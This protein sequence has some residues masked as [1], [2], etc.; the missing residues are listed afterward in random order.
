MRA[1][2]AAA[3]TP[4]TALSDL[5]RP[6]LAALRAE[7]DACRAW[8]FGEALPFWATRGVDPAG[9]F[10]ER[11]TPDGRPTREPRRARLI[12]R[13]VYAFATARGLGWDGPAEAL[14]RMGLATLAQR[15][16]CP[17]GMV[18][19]TYGPDAGRVNARFDLYD[20]AFVLFAKAA[21]A[22]GGVAPADGLAEEARGLLER[23]RAGWAHPEAGFEESVPRALP[24]RANPHM[25]LL[26][27]ALAWSET[28][29]DPCWTAAAEEIV[30]LCLSRF[31]DPATGALR[32]VFDGDWRVAE[33]LPDDVVEPGHQY[34]WG[35]L[36]L[37]WSDRRPEDAVLARAAARL[38]E[39]GEAHGVDPVR[40]LAINALGTGD[41]RPVDRLAR[42]WPQ[43]ERIKALVALGR[44]ADSPAEADAAFD[45]AARAAAGLRRYF[46]HPVRGCWWEHL[47]EDGARVEEP[48]RASSLY[49]ITCAIAE[50]AAAVGP[51]TR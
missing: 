15:L 21:A 18:M 5:G 30:G 2:A 51:Q 3:E 50:M 44:R 25:H 10:F 40:G 38:I 41:L 7:T 37:R 4:L 12:A 6:G 45:A 48:T 26:E 46:E 32:E 36:L 19:A 13:Q 29:P 33:G 27:A 47:G 14:C 16:T 22:R 20:H 11:F 31:L 23:I 35:W 43:T 9:G 17:K 49:H 34:E 24:L 42:L 8:L 28:A 39:I 1:G